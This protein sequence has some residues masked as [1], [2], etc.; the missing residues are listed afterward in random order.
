MNV[1]K[2]AFEDRKTL[3]NLNEIDLLDIIEFLQEDRKQWINQFTKTH[4]ECVD[5]HQKNQELKKQ[6]VKVLDDYCRLDARKD[7]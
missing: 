6:L 7:A 1:E 3:A 4:N 5:I 2:I